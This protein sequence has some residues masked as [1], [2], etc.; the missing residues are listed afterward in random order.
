MKK[1]FLILIVLGTMSCNVTQ[2]Y[3]P[4]F[5]LGMSEEQFKKINKS[6]VRAY[7]DETGVLIYRTYNAITETFKFFRFSNQKL[8]QFGEGYYP[9]DYKL[10]PIQ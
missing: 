7:G 9:D 4:K 5:T 1:L 6:A 2:Y 10:L 3:E 8:V